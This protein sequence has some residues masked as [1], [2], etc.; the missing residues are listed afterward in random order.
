MDLKNYQS[1]DVEVVEILAEQGF[2]VS[3]AGTNVE[4]FGD[5]GTW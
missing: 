2:T 4:G 1:P 5:G 3:P